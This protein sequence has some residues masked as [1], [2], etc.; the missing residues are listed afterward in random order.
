MLCGPGE[1]W[2]FCIGEQRLGGWLVN[3]DDS[4]TVERVGNVLLS[5][6]CS[7]HVVVEV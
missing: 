7:R 1:V 4:R 2:D 6:V 3:G 5:V